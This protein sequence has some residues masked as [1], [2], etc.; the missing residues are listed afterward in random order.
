LSS[1]RPWKNARQSSEDDN[2]DDLLESFGK[3]SQLQNIVVRVA[4]DNPEEYELIAGNRR[5]TAAR[6]L[7]W[8]HIDARVVAADDL[9]GEV[10]ALEE[11]LRRKTMD[12]ESMAVARLVELY[13]HLGE[14]HKNGGDRRSKEF[15]EKQARGEIVTDPFKRVAKLVGQ[16]DRTV[17]RKAK[18]TENGSPQLKEALRLGK[19]RLTEAE[20]L[21]RLT[22]EDQQR[23]LERALPRTGR[24][25]ATPEEA[26]LAAMQQARTALSQIKSGEL[27]LTGYRELCMELRMVAD[28]LKRHSP[29][30]AVVAPQTARSARG[31]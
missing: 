28:L 3:V 14:P 1:I 6:R 29:G 7:G 2:V 12:G 8:T 21:A 26:T 20:R 27:S 15:L 18:I 10:C 11:N 22:P 31:Q 30:A 17:R 25:A 9:L 4:P 5:V 24:H 23:A 19:I 16:S 13:K